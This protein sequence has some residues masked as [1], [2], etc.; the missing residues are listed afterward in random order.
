MLEVFTRVGGRE[1]HRSSSMNSSH[2]RCVAPLLG[3]I[4]V[5]GGKVNPLGL[6]NIPAKGYPLGVGDAGFEPATFAV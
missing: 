5:R 1:I 6:P 2:G 3:G 4:M